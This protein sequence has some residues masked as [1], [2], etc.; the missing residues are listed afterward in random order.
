MFSQAPLRDTVKKMSRK[1]DRLMVL[2]SMN[3]RTRAGEAVFALIEAEILTI[4][5]QLTLG[6]HGNFNMVLP[7]KVLWCCQ[8]G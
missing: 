1:L 7:V 2:C 5:M 6:T 8:L 4:C 3:Q